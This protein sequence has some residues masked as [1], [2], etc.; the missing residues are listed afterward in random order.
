MSRCIYIDIRCIVLKRNVWY[1]VQKAGEANWADIT[2][3]LP[4]SNSFFSLSVSGSV[5]CYLE[6]MTCIDR[7]MLIHGKNLSPTT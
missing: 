6:V 4:I 2:S 3:S 7:L 5:I 1:G